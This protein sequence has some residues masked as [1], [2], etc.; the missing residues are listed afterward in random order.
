MN[1]NGDPYVYNVQV[2]L[3]MSYGNDE[4]YNIVSED[5]YIGWETI[6]GLTRAL[7][8]ELGITNTAD[9]FG[10]ST[11]SHFNQ[12]FPNG[13]VQQA[14]EDETESN[15]YAIIQG[16]LLCKGY[17]TGLNTV[18]THFYNGTGNAVKS[19]KQ[20]A[21]V[22]DTTSTVTLNIMKALLSMDYFYSYD[23]SERTQKIQAMQRYMNYNYED[24]I[25]IRPCDGIYSRSTNTALIYAIQAEEGMSTSIAN[26]NCGPATKRCLPNIPYS[27]GYPKNGQ[28]YGLKYNGNAYTSTEIDRF[29]ILVNMALYFNGFG[30]GNISST[31]VS[32]D[33]TQFQSLYAL[34]TSGNIDYTTWLSLLISCGDIERSVCACDCATILTNAKA[35]TLYNN[36]YR[37]IGRYLCGTIASGQ[38]KALSIDEL[39]IAFNKNLRIFPIYQSE[40]YYVNYFNK[41]QGKEDAREAM[42]YANK[43]KIPANTVIYFAVD[44]DP[45]DYQITDKIIPYFQGIKETIGTYR[46]GIYGTRNVCQRVCNLGYAVY[47]FVS[48]MSTGYSGNL[49]FQIPNNW[50]FDQFDTVTVG[51]GN[52]SIEIDK[53][54]YSGED[55]GFASFIDHPMF[56]TVLNSITSVYNMAKSYTNNN[57]SQSNILTLQYIRRNKY[58]SAAWN[59]VAG[60]IDTNFIDEV[61]TYCNNLS[62]DFYDPISLNRGQDVKYDME[63]F[64]ATLNALLYEVGSGNN[65]SL[66]AVS[67]LYAGWGGD[68]ISFSAD[69]YEKEQDGYSG[70]L[71][72][73]AEDNICQ[74]E[75]TR[76]SSS[77][78]IA[79]VDAINISKKLLLNQEL[80]TVFNNYFFALGTPDAEQRTH[81]WILDLGTTN[82]ENNCDFLVSDDTRVFVNILTK[83]D[84]V[85][86][87]NVETAIDA[88]KAFVYNEH[89]NNR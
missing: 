66:D 76:F 58:N 40:G 7:Q 37:Y 48:D 81:R 5:G 15:I 33:I 62:F 56:S 82:F 77:D 71:S 44:C 75:D 24:Y 45:L 13:I 50:S 35:T 78:Y 1:N 57:I 2:W 6:Y 41:N 65:P 22:N 89:I 86:E 31:I 69:I 85:S 61:D 27:G 88:F 36:G 46:I 79:D 18:T 54:G 80:P 28:T 70:D 4:R 49:G 84:S 52:G 23:T 60:S 83:I 10:P 25:G 30:T 43:L 55:N 21:G 53:D 87:D 64:A 3:N 20:D 29:K 63:H 47:S 34:N 73:W 19:L 11:E 42:K 32:N 68:A 59:I 67:N 72:D 17:P 8:I 74:N 26:G 14:D 9:N 12:Q 16:A 51:S 38:S 39:T